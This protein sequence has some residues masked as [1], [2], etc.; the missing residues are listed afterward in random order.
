MEAVCLMKF[1]CGLLLTPRQSRALTALLH[2]NGWI[3]RE[4]I[5]R[6]TGASNGPEV[7]RQLR[8]RFGLCKRLHLVC[9]R[10]TV[11]DRDGRKSNPGRYRLTPEG[12]AKLEEMGCCNA[13]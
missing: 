3:S 4:M 13:H 10:V 6:I 2:S 11:S 7:I 12:R 1:A 8:N 5:D 9:E